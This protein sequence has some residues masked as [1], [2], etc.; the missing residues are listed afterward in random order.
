MLLMGFRALFENISTSGWNMDRASRRDNRTNK[1]IKN[2][3]LNELQRCVL[4]AR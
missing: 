3:K 1:N 2:N 4:V